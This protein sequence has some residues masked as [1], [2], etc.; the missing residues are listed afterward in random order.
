MIY[1]LDLF[2]IGDAIVQSCRTTIGYFAGMIYSLIEYL[3]HIFE[4]LGRAEI[5]EDSFVQMLYTRVGYILGIFMLFKLIFSLIQALLEPEKINDKKT[6]YAEIIKRSVIAIVLLGITPS[7][8]R[9]AFKIQNFIVGG[10]SNNNIIYKLIAGSN[11]HYS[12]AIGRQLAVN[13]YFDFVTDNDE[14]YLDNGMIDEILVSPNGGVTTNENSYIQRFQEDNWENLKEKI[15]EENKDIM[16]TLDYLAIKSGGVYVIELNWIPLL[17]VGLIVCYMMILY[18]IQVAIRVVQ[19]AYLQLIAP[20]PILSYISD[21]DGAF[22]KWTKQCA[23]TY[24]DLFIR[25]AIIYFVMSLISEVLYQFEQGAGRLYLTAGL[26]NEKKMVIVL[27]KAFIIIGLLMFGK[28]VPEL[29]KEL[30]PS[31]SSGSLEFGFKSPKK[32]IGDIPGNKLVK[33]LA[34]NTIGRV[35]KKTISG[36]DSAHAG[37]GFKQGWNNDRG[38]FGTWFNKK[39]ETLTPYSYERSKNVAEGT[40]KINE[41]DTNWK[42]GVKIAQ[43]LMAKRGLGAYGTANGWEGALDGTTRD[44]YKAIFKHEEFI[45]SKMNLDSASSKRDELQRA[46]MQVQAGGTWTDTATGTVY[47]VAGT[48]AGNSLADLSKLLN[49]QDK[50]VS[51]LENVHSAVEQKFADDA[52]TAKVF[53]FIKSNSENPANPSETRTGKGI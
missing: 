29:L 44:N 19:L 6:G 2:G 43:T 45:Q 18:C 17:A 37:Y 42:N 25:C 14:P 4:L 13:L 41:I 39:R 22:K 52:N 27:V 8:F 31:L 20:V 32:V 35:A 53:K 33:G 30:F 16:Y 10:N 9:E 21:P 36:I 38:K 12:S 23:T 34:A 11:T 48:G 26:A 51:G 5:I 7:L 15:I 40:K 24:L 50:K 49:S 46:V 28:K 47:S 3:Y 1:N